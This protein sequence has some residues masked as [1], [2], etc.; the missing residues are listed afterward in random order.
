MNKYLKESIRHTAIGLIIIVLWVLYGC[1]PFSFKGSCVPRAVFSA[2][3]YEQEAGL[4][5]RIVIIEIRKGYDHAQA[6]G[7]NGIEWVWLEEAID[8]SVI[9]GAQQ[10]EGG[11][12]KYLTLDE[13]L[14]EHR[15]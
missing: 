2:W 3:T 15:G 10:H 5:A 14:M 1:A 12:V 4:P 7:F 13:I 8:Y 11:I 6:Q 9:R